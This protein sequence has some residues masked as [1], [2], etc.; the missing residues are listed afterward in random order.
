M[1][2]IVQAWIFILVG[3]PVAALGAWLLYRQNK[4]PGFHDT[5][6]GSFSRAWRHLP[7]TIFI[8]VAGIF[9]L[10]LGILGIGLGISFLA[11]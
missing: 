9:F 3:L 6:I 4:A 10:C 7:R 8:I 2:S 11:G 5:G 1:N